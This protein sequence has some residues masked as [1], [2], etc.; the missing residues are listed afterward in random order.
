MRKWV[1]L[2]FILA[3]SLRLVGLSSYPKGFNADEA[4]FGYDAYSILKTGKDQWGTK[5][6][7]TLRAFG[8]FRP[9]LYTYLVIP[10]VAVFGLNEFATRLPN[11]LFGS[12][13]VLVT[14]FMVVEVFK[15][16]K[17]A[18][19]LG[20]LAS[21]LIAISPWHISLSRAGFESNLTSFFMP[22]AVLA[23]YKG[24]EKPKWM[25][26]SALSFGLNLFTYHSGRLAT[27]LIIGL[28]LFINRQF[29]RANIRKFIPAAVILAVFFVG[30]LMSIFRGGS[31]RISD[32][33]IFNPTDNWKAVSDRR[34]Q[35]VLIG[36]P[37]KLARVFSN[38]AVY[39]FSQFTQNFL[40]YL[41]PNFL[42]L[43][44]AGDPTYAMLPGVGVL[45]LVELPFLIVGLIYFLKGKDRNLGFFLAWIF[46]G[47]LPA[48]FSKGSGYVANRA[49]V[50]MPAIQVVSA[51]GLLALVGFKQKILMPTLI[52]LLFI[53]LA[54]FAENYIYH[55]PYNAK[56]M[57][58]GWKEVVPYL[59]S[60]EKSYDKIIVSRSFSEPQIYI[61]FY[62]KWNPAD[63]Q[64][65]SQD[66]LRYEKL[67][68]PFVDQL[69]DYKLGKYEFRDINYQGLKGKQKN[70]LVG[71]QNEFPETI[72]TLKTFYYPDKSPSFLVV[73]P[74]QVNVY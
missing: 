21:L 22:L 15:K 27:P 59:N 58:Y 36:E 71:R 41:S 10:S 14:Y 73:D 1:L 9:P 26:V 35:A 28:L 63:Y 53:G 4:T 44:G 60:I 39:L 42:F 69:G 32:V 67:K 34:Y 25:L 33:T 49:A 2:I 23:F 19:K 8:D 68:L 45:Y 54:F 64:R 52:F 31:A 37:D 56:A 30:V 6:P 43:Q 40:T 65:E 55:S 18:Q 70:L 38:K 62:N 47:I 29:I 13:A 24:L 7:L 57:N 12:L 48:A 51:Y 50:I 16:D 20:I 17:N 11:A 3:L 5:L 66:W 46:L 61:A 72:K 74:N